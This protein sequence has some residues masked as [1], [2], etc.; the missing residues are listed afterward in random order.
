MRY[1]A[2][3]KFEIIE[4][5]QQSSLSIRGHWLQSGP[6]APG[7]VQLQVSG[8]SPA[9]AQPSAVTR[10]SGDAHTGHRTASTGHLFS[11]IR[12]FCAVDSASRQPLPTAVLLD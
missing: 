11:T 4:L 1:S 12:R 8:L 5:V 7:I 3:E 10:A 2:S 9:D 6:R